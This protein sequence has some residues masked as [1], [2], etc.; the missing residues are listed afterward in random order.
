VSFTQ[1]NIELMSLQLRESLGSNITW[2]YE[3]RLNVMLSEF[4]QNKSDDILEKLRLSL[5]DEWHS[6]TAK[7]LPS[8][9]KS[10]LGELAK[11]SNH[12]MIL[13][14]PATEKTPAIV[15]F[16]WPWDHGGTYSLRIKVL[17]QSYENIPE[18]QSSGIF[19]WFKGL[20]A[21]S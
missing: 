4:A 18:Q 11:I 2:Q 20:F 7:K 14:T 19:G 5:A 9:L 12:Q 21:T 16:W 6:K 1:E 10:Q 15:A 3:Q 8:T 17:E 13:A